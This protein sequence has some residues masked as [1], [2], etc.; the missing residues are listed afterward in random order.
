MAREQLPRF[1]SPMLARAGVP[2]EA[3]GWAYEVKFDGMRAELHIQAGKLCLRSRPGR[4]CTSNDPGGEYGPYLAI[5]AAPVYQDVVRQFARRAP[6]EV[7]QG[8]GEERGGRPLRGEPR[9]PVCRPQPRAQTRE[10]RLAVLVRQTSSPSSSSRRFRSSPDSV[11][12][13]VEA[14]R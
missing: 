2:C 7:E 11:A 6:A 9:L 13:S 8:E 12:G 10:V 4:E 1:V 5:D 3:D 14:S